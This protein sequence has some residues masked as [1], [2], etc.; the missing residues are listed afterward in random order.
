MEPQRLDI[1]TAQ[2]SAFFGSMPPDLLGALIEDCAVV[3]LAEGGS[4]FSQGDPAQSVFAVLDGMVKLTRN[5]PNGE[6][7]VVEVFHPGESF[8]EALAFERAVYPVNAIALLDC[9]I[10]AAPNDV[11]ISRI[12]SRPEAFGSILGATYRHLHRLLVQIEEL[13]STS[14]H[15]R[16]ARYI[17][18]KATPDRGK[19][20]AELPFEKKV[21][22]SLLGIKPETLS[23]AFRRLEAHGLIVEGRTARVADMSALRRFVDGD[24]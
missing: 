11:V 1:A 24:A 20:V 15:R 18:A 4:L 8:A 21:L 10:L 12:S 17:L 22:A 13:K 7:V 3:D 2:R 5:L 16:L 9:R 19:A 23:R 14:G 6:E